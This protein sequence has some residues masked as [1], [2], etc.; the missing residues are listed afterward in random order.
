MSNLPRNVFLSSNC[1]HLLQI[2][3]WSEC[4]HQVHEN[5]G[6]ASKTGQQG[7]SRYQMPHLQREIC[8]TKG[9]CLHFEQCLIILGVIYRSFATVMYMYI[10]QLSTEKTVPT[11]LWILAPSKAIIGLSNREQSILYPVFMPTLCWVTNGMGI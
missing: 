6:R 11:L 10:S 8:P 3:V 9:L 4:A 1:H 5:M 2:W 7:R